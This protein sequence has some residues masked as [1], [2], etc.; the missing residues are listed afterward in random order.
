MYYGALGQDDAL[1]Q[2]RKIMESTCYSYSMDKCLYPDGWD[3]SPDDAAVPVHPDCATLLAAREANKDAFDQIEESMVYCG[4]PGEY[5]EMPP[6][7]AWVLGGVAVLALA[8]GVVAG[9][10]LF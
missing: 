8:A 1:A 2:A 6:E 9:G 5:C 4:L 3:D 10:A 7:A